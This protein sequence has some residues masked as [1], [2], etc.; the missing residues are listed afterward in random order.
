[1]TSK[2]SNIIQGLESL[3][4]TYGLVFSELGVNGGGSSDIEA[5]FKPAL[6]EKYNTLQHQLENLKMTLAQYRGWEGE[7]DLP[8]LVTTQ[9]TL[10]S[11]T[12]VVK[13]T[14]KAIADCTLLGKIYLD[15]IAPKRPHS[16]GKRKLSLLASK[17]HD[18]ISDLDHK[19]G[20]YSDIEELNAINKTDPA[21]ITADNVYSC[22]ISSSTF[23]LDI[24]ILGDGSIREVKLVHISM[25]T[26]E[27]KETSQELAD[28]LTRSIRSNMKEFE[29]KVR[30]ICAQD[31]LF[32]RYKAFNLQKALTVLQDDYSAVA[33]R[34]GERDEAVAQASYGRIA[35]DCCGVKIGY[36]QTLQQRLMGETGHI[37]YLEMEE[38]GAASSYKMPL[39]QQIIEEEQGDS[40]PTFLSD[41]SMLAA[42]DCFMC[43]IRLVCRLE[44]PV[45]VTAEIMSSIYGVLGTGYTAPRMDGVRSQLA[46][47]ENQVIGVTTRDKTPLEAPFD[48]VVLGV[49]QRYYYAGSMHVGMEVSRI[50]LG[51]SSQML[52]IIQLL[53]QQLVFNG[54][55][56]SCFLPFGD[57]NSPA[58]KIPTVNPSEEDIPIFE[59]TCRPPHS[60]NIIF[61]HPRH[62]EF[63]SLTI[64]V[65][66]GGVVTATIES[67]NPPDP[68]M[69][70]QE[71]SMTDPTST[72]PFCSN[73]Y[74]T[75]LL[76]AS[77]SIPVTFTY[78]LKES[79]TSSSSSSST[80]T[81]TALQPAEP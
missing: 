33:R 81:P 66:L 17:L 70:D 6:Y 35:V 80:S 13:S 75:K 3:W 27:D 30:R 40:N 43:P 45:H 39:V 76:T 7:K 28:D 50:P 79:L 29:A 51:N 59:V 25:A 71:V 1:M 68:S 55:F 78:L 4:T 60:I 15:S 61:L 53:R 2:E 52:G 23:L 38:G 73:E 16:Q 42:E 14:R 11:T 5:Q 65:G 9:K 54:L 49:H 34:L 26:G 10:A 48:A 22:N 58:T 47:L 21:E 18:L 37:A 19:Y 32:R 44:P 72:N 57:A 36:A 77:N 31:L 24:F 74:L 8:R 64:Q 69:A 62:V 12:S 67:S 46:W 56:K 20:T 41:G 63:S